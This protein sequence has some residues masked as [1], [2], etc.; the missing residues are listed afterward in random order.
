[1][2]CYYSIQLAI[3]HCCS[4]CNPSI[5][6]SVCLLSEVNNYIV[7]SYRVVIVETNIVTG[8]TNKIEFSYVL[9]YKRILLN[10][11]KYNKI[12]RLTMGQFSKALLAIDKVH[13]VPQK[14]LA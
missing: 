4:L 9:K 3:I 10:N 11:I 2:L 12:N 5:S 1:M 6:W 7:R 13:T 14:T 8:R